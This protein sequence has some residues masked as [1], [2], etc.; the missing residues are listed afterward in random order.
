M[1][2]LTNDKSAG[3][4]IIQPSKGLVNFI[5]EKNCSFL[6]CYLW[7]I[8]HL[9]TPVSVLVDKP[10]YQMTHMTSFIQSKEF[11]LHAMKR[12]Q[13]DLLYC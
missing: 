7:K 12:N 4:K 10:W 3:N 1:N 5:Y 9:W 13:L 2:L 11:V 6:I 8:K